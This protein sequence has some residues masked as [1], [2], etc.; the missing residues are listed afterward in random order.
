MKILILCAASMSD[1]TSRKLLDSSRLFDLG[2]RSKS[3]LRKR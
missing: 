3:V 2:W 1:Y